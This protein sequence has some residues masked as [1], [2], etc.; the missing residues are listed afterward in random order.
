[1]NGLASR[2]SLHGT[3]SG[4]LARYQTTVSRGQGTMALVHW[5]SVWLC[6]CNSG[7]TLAWLWLPA[8][9]HLHRCLSA[10]QPL[11]ALLLIQTM[12]CCHCCCRP[13]GL[14]AHALSVQQPAEHAAQ[15]R[16]SA[17][18]TAGDQPG[19]QQ[20][21]QP[22]C[23]PGRTGAAEEAGAEWQPAAGAAAGAGLPGMRACVPL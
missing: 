20:A 18:I 15:Q 13:A 5:C 2:G 23:W 16:H 3:A 22:A 14:P 11:S 12:C 6:G 21:D 19:W 17:D 9:L 7:I 10:L 8:P 1:M 4:N